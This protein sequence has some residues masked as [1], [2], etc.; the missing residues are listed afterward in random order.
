VVAYFATYY[1]LFWVLDDAQRT[2]LFRLSPSYFDD[3]RASWGLALAG[4]HALAGNHDRARAYAD[5]ARVALETQVGDA[6]GNAQL[7]V[8]LGTALAYLGRKPDAIR[9][10][11]RAMELLPATA[12]AF[13]AAYNQH[14][15]A[16]IYVLVGERERA[17]DELEALLARPYFV[18]PGWLRIDPTFEAL[19]S[20]PRFK[21]LV[22]GTA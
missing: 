3:D 10:G 1:D 21:K 8:L 17:L 9:E 11:R 4:V 16:R 20:H 18:S 22:E 13:G 6:P 19:R 12:D 15:L 2:L 14:Q 5:S 7:H